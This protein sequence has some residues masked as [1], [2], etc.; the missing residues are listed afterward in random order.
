[1]LSLSY[2]HLRIVWKSDRSSQVC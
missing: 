1:M 2:D